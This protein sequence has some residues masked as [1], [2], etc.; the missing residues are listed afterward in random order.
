MN[1]AGLTPCRLDE[2]PP[3]KQNS[4]QKNTPR[5]TSAAVVTMKLSRNIKRESESQRQSDQLR[6][7]SACGGFRATADFRPGAG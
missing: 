7:P 1:E 6:S 3:E 2:G 5:V 4:K